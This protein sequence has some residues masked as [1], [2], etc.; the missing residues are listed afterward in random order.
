MDTD[1]AG[2]AGESLRAGAGM[3][4]WS[5]WRERCGWALPQP[6]SVGEAVVGRRG[7]RMRGRWLPGARAGRFT[8]GYHMTGFQPGNGRR[9]QVRAGGVAA[10]WNG[11]YRR[12]NFR[13]FSGMGRGWTAWTAWTAWTQ[14]RPGA[15]G[16]R[17]GRGRECE[18]GW[19][20]GSAAAGLCHS[21]AP[22]ERRWLAGGADC[23]GGNG[24]WQARGE[25]DRNGG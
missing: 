7:L 6:R 18:G 4:G 16:S 15:G 8:P 23:G 25:E 9:F 21:R 3:R 14:I 11:S 24:G 17:C 10:H 22:L 19:S 13:H 12:A 20:G 1:K 2:R 5:V